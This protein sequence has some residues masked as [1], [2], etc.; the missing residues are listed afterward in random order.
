[1]GL[2]VVSVEFPGQ[3]GFEPAIGKPVLDADA[4]QQ[5]FGFRPFVRGAVRISDQGVDPGARDRIRCPCGNDIVSGIPALII[6]QVH[7][8]IHVPKGG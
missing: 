8:G 5:L 6:I 2:A 1:M 7:L 3:N 4:A